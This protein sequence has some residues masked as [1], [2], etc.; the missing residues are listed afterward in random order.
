VKAEDNRSKIK[1]QSISDD[2]CNWSKPKNS[3]SRSRR[4]YSVDVLT[5]GCENDSSYFTLVSAARIS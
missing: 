5:L 2:L 1:D 4:F 3:T